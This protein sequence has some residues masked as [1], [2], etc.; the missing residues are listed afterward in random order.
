MKVMVLVKANPDSEAGKM[1]SPELFRAMAAFNEH[2]VE[3]GV[4]LAGE[5]LH[6]TAKGKRVLCSGQQRTVID[7]PFPES[8]DLVSG[9]WLWQVPS[10]QDAL[11]WVRRSPF[12]DGELELRPVYEA[13]DFGDRLPPDVA[14]KEAELRSRPRALH[15]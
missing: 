11:D 7:G 5:G 14:A 12:Q 3:A 8:K 15:S 2:L 9:F 13:A 1:P 4:L 10:M 6:P